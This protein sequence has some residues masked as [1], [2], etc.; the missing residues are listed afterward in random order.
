MT[1][2]TRPL[3]GINKP[4]KHPDMSTPKKYTAGPWLPGLHLNV[5]DEHGNRIAF[6]RSENIHADMCL[7]AAAPELLAALEGAIGALEFSRDYHSDDGSNEDQAFAQDTL[8][9]ARKAI[10]KA[11]LE[12]WDHDWRAWHLRSMSF[13]DEP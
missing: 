1:E 13:R 5:T 4:K 11:K 2:E 8:D 3:S 9:A 7:I 10:A 6:V 12:N